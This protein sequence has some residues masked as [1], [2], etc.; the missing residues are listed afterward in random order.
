MNKLIKLIYYNKKDKKERSK[1]LPNIKKK[2]KI[3]ILLAQFGEAAESFKEYLKI[4][5]EEAVSKDWSINFLLA[6]A[7]YYQ[8]NEEALVSFKLGIEMPEK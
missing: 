6:T 1:M 3:H 8:E 4:E 7:Y 5:E 2:G